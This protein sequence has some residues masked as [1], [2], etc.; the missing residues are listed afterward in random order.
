MAQVGIIEQVSGVV[1]AIASDGSVK[2]LVIGDVVNEGDVINTIGHDS[3]VKI[4]LF[5][6]KELSLGA[7][8]RSLLDNS[9]VSSEVAD[10]GDVTA[11]QQALLDGGQ[12]PTEAPAA[13]P[14]TPES[15]GGITEAYVAQMS[16]ARGDVSSYNLGTKGRGIDNLDGNQNN[17]INHEPIGINDVGIAVEEGSGG[18]GQYDAPVVAIGNVLSNDLDD[19]LPNPDGDLDVSDVISSNTENV[20]VLDD[21]GNYTL[22]GEFGTL[23][24][25]AETGAYTYTVDNDNTTVDELNISD[26]LRENFTYTVTDGLLDNT[27][28]LTITINGS[29]DAPI[30]FDDRTGDGQSDVGY[31]D[32][33]RGE[34]ISTQVNSIETAGLES[35]QVFNLDSNELSGLDMLYVQNP[36]GDTTEYLS[37]ID[38]ISQAVSHGMT[39]I[40][41]DRALTEVN[42][43]LPGDNVF[44]VHYLSG[45][46]RDIEIVENDLETGVGGNID[47]SS[48]DGGNYS[49]HGYIDLDS[50]PGGAEVLMTDGN[51]LHVVTF[52]YS[53]GEGT[54][55]YST[56]PL[57]YYL[58]G[59]GPSDVNVNMNIYAANLLE[60]LAAQ[61]AESVGNNA[62][63]EGTS[64]EEGLYDAPV[65]AEGNVLGNDTDVDNSH[66][67]LSVTDVDGI[68]I[69]TTGD[70]VIYGLYGTLTM[71]SDGSFLYSTND[72]NTDVNALNIGEKLSEV[73][74]YTVSDNEE[75]GAKTDTATLTITIEGANDAPVISIDNGDSIIGTIIEDASQQI[76]SVSGTI[77][78]ND[79]DINDSH[80]ITHVLK[81]VDY[82]SNNNSLD[83]VFD[84]TYNDLNPAPTSIFGINPTDL[85]TASQDGSEHQSGDINWNFT[86][87]NSILQPLAT[88]ETI[89]LVYAITVTD[90]N[91]KTD[92]QDITITIEGTNDSVILSSSD[93]TGLVTETSTINNLIDTGVITFNDVDL[94]DTHTVSVSNVSDDSLGT[95]TATVS[96]VENSD[97]GTLTWTY[98]VNDIDV[99]YL[100]FEET[101]VETFDV[102]I[103]DGHGSTSTQTVSVTIVG[104]N[105]QPEVSS[106][107]T[108]VSEESLDDTSGEDSLFSGQLTV[109]DADTSDTSHTFTVEDNSYSI[110]I[111]TTNAALLDMLSDYDTP[112]NIESFVEGLTNGEIDFNFTDVDSNDVMESASITL[113]STLVEALMRVDLI[114]IELDS[115]GSYTIASP[116]FNMLGASDTASVSFD[117]RADDGHGVDN[118]LPDENSLSEVA[119]AT[120]VI[121]GTNDQ[122]VAQDVTKTKWETQLKDN[123]SEDALFEGNLDGRYYLGSDEDL[124]DSLTMKYFGVDA[125]NDGKIDVTTISPVQNI[126]GITS[127]VDPS[128]TVVIVNENG[129]F[130]VTNPT[131]DSLAVGEEATVTFEYYI[132][133]GSGVVVANNDTTNIH[134]TPI[135]DTKTVTLTI[136]GTNDQ[137]VVENVNVG[138]IL[139]SEN[140]ET[141]VTGW[142]NNSNTNAGEL[143]SFLGRF[144]GPSSS[145]DGDQEV[146]KTFN[147][148]S[149]HAGETVSINFDMYRIDSWDALGYQG[150]GEERFQVFINDS[151]VSNELNGNSTD[152]S[153]T[154]DNEF[155][156]WGPERI[157]HYTIQAQVDENGNIKL[158]FGSTLHQSIGDESWG[159]DNLTISSGQIIYESIDGDTIYSD[160]L[161]MVQDDDTNDTHIYSIDYSSISVDNQSI[162]GLHITLTDSSTGAYTM[163]G[164][165]NALALGESAIVTFQYRVD[166]QSTRPG[167]DES[168]YSEYETVTLTITGTN[169]VPVIEDTS[170]ITAIAKEAGNNDDG[171]IVDGTIATGQ[172]IS[173]DVDNN[174][175]A[176]WSH[177]GGETSDYGSFTIDSSTGIWTY[178]VDVT[179]GSAADKLE[180]G[181]SYNETFEVTVT[182]EHGA[183]DTKVVTVTIQGTNDSPIAIQDHQI[184]VVSKDFLGDGDHTNPWNTAGV[185]IDGTIHTIGGDLN[186]GIGVFQFDENWNLLESKGFDTFDP[187]DSRHTDGLND[188][189]EFV[190]YLN[191]I[192]NDAQIG[193]RIVIATS[194]EFTNKLNFEGFDGYAALKSI[195]A[196]QS[197]IDDAAFRSS[198]ALVVEKTDSGW[199]VIAEDYKADG[200]VRLDLTNQT[201]D[202]NTAITIDVLANDTDID[203]GDN[204]STFS[205]DSVSFDSGVP[206]NP[207]ATVNIDAN[208]KLVFDPGSD[209]DSLAIGE[210]AIVVVNYT[211]SDDSGATSS[212]T[213]TIVVTGTNDAPI[214][215]LYTQTETA[216]SYDLETAG[217]DNV[218]G[219]YTLDS[220]GNPENPTLI[221]T[222][223][224]DQNYRHLLSIQDSAEN[225]KF[226][227][228]ADGE[229]TVDFDSASNL[230][231]VT[232]NNG[233]WKIAVDGNTINKYVYF[234]DPS[235]NHDGKDHFDLVNNND[236]TYQLNIEDLPNLGDEDFQDVVLTLSEKD[237]TGTGY[238]TTFVEA[239]NNDSGTGSVS[240]VGRGVSITDVDDTN[241]QSAIITLTNAK[242]GDFLEYNGTTYNVVDTNGNIIVSLDFSGTL[243][244]YQSALANVKFGSTSENPD[245]TDRVIEVTVNDGNDNSNTATTIVHVD[246]IN[247]NPIATDDIFNDGAKAGV[248][249]IHLYDKDG[250]DVLEGINDSLYT[251]KDHYYFDHSSMGYTGYNYMGTSTDGGVNDPD[252]ND[253]FISHGINIGD[254]RGGVIAFSDGTQ[255]I[256]DTA[257]NGIVRGDYHESA[258]IYYKAYTDLDTVAL[259]TDEDSSVI[260][261]VLAN[262]VDVDGD[263][264]SI[265]SI[266]PP[267]DEQGNPLGNVEIEDGKIKFTPN[268]H[269]DSLQ[270]GEF[271]NVNIEYTI[272]D[273]HGG[274]D[275]ATATVVI[276][277]TNDNPDAVDDGVFTTNEDTS[278]VIGVD[279]LLSNDSDVEDDA[280]TIQSVQN[281]EHGTVEIQRGIL[282]NQDGATNEALVYDSRGSAEEILG[283]ATSFDISISFLAEN[284]SNSILSYAAGSQYSN[285]VLLYSNNDG[286]KVQVWIN[287]TQNYVNVGSS[288]NDGKLHDIRLQWQSIDGEAKLSVD[289]DVKETFIIAQGETI[290]ENGVLMLGQEQDSI[291]GSLDSSQVL[292]GEYIDAAIS[293]NGTEKAHWQM[294][295][296]ENGITEDSVGD[297]DLTAVGDVSLLEQV[298]FTPDA[299]YS[300]DASF[301]YTINDSNGGTD[302]ATVY[303]NI[304]DTIDMYGGNNLIINGSFETM[305][306]DTDFAY[307]NNVE[308]W[309]N[310]SSGGKIEVW[311][312]D[313]KSEYQPTDG[314]KL[315]ELDV[316]NNNV[317]NLSQTISSLTEG[318]TYLL[319]FDASM[320]TYDD[321]DNEFKVLWNGEEIS[322]IHES[323]MQS[324]NGNWET[325]GFE[326]TA[327]SGDNIL[328]FIETSN[329][330]DSMGPLLDNI[331][332]YAEISNPT[333]VQ[334]LFG[335]DGSDNLVYDNADNYIDGKDGEDTLQINTDTLDLSN[336]HNIEIIEL[337]DNAKLG[338][339]D[340]E[341]TAKDVFEMTNENHNLTIAGDGEV[342]LSADWTLDATDNSIY[343]AVYSGENIILHIDDTSTINII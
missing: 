10:N 290:A 297:F 71:H 116:L 263:I 184:T 76:E 108:T 185:E 31:Y 67:Q 94:T 239:A 39:L 36:Y 287:G 190:N 55:V 310:N 215:D 110:S 46:G 104:T 115:D 301:E 192:N 22:L 24:L 278:L 172:M 280:I 189:E 279:S 224:N 251:T 109:T 264:I 324:G 334:G 123:P 91:G 5:N 335:T 149:E 47:D 63:E 132:N 213:A 337:S 114:T 60:D 208:N 267:T 298:V 120:L 304:Q 140:F 186:R 223:T 96:E 43:I 191:S 317:D 175:I 308:G 340:Y 1:Q 204:P 202:E 194:D 68:T 214:L 88:G 170:V 294:D 299:D 101:K 58:N 125:D 240:I 228:V 199:N 74:T 226:F 341:L 342:D 270:Q 323:D 11:I 164:D 220:D 235:L 303:L 4:S 211:M 236:G 230:A 207:T 131:F 17:Q 15:A 66:D 40:I 87:P 161:P 64:G 229:D 33:S 176:T 339:D 154:S 315:V 42:E 153:M 275:S 141:A 174:S 119:T 27:A 85:F 158:G 61:Y 243:S 150:E 321:F 163:N 48:L 248:Q 144:G 209:F 159:I 89:D 326:V 182:D 288:I 271:E 26:T 325:F 233:D 167:F 343:S 277:G 151:L 45:D 219:I 51:P 59:S 285:D 257:S 70:T 19:G 181:E 327:G 57:D 97:N 269:F 237:I 314:D 203:N 8:E 124:L 135:S 258:Y 75:F 152:Y 138:E 195:G 254:L 247:D 136:K 139:V 196:T 28:N 322:T 286:T 84:A 9:V 72:T 165:F 238:E 86:V 37:Q 95:L 177:S 127:V 16:N 246:S 274:T 336:V 320:R 329:S 293:V 268:D 78:F 328:T 93:V 179:P 312:K 25:N 318:D 309:S 307:Y 222:N 102:T 145:V 83:T 281:S 183:T 148:G 242:D 62:Q 332:L 252:N 157:N 18:E 3:S 206:Q 231:F 262:D 80:T 155:T 169:D 216:I 273:G 65:A 232:D 14:D 266:T 156:G 197:V 333:P 244:Q 21:D 198:Y 205:L 12:L 130:T 100:G 112:T 121:E 316:D 292:S 99:Q 253:W 137:P 313:F 38:A 249:V 261:D 23:V 218:I 117:Y 82:D 284:G 241:I 44:N 227:I 188:T 306:T 221:L 187:Y 295:N 90:A 210:S 225:I 143:T 289:G 256:I 29:N 146:Y 52:S 6:G 79:V 250:N 296:L 111:S 2:V 32:M 133:D 217:Y 160:I 106:T 134:E 193:T 142:N 302:T 282:I 81:S 73:F 98:T 54:V 147:F 319:K 56:I 77:S 113:S 331:Q 276:T 20:A 162:T 50:L 245:E 305:P 41:H 259:T 30:A 126:D 283:G 255:G 166:D 311:D 180:E 260:I 122:P 265:S 105:D 300:G 13:G 212:S 53:Y 129:K 118:N 173:S 69:T 338:D 234:S 168:R 128:Q 330:D 34:G 7:D 107:V 272:S 92:V 49:N 103:D 291:G 178:T 171:T 35:V 200:E 201:T